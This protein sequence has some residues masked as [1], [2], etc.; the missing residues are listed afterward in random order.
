MVRDCSTHTSTGCS[1]SGGYRTQCATDY[2]GEEV[3]SCDQL[4]SDVTVE[5]Y[6]RLLRYG[7]PKD[8]AHDLACD[9]VFVFGML[10]LEMLDKIP[11]DSVTGD[12]RITG[13]ILELLYCGTK[14]S[15]YTV[16]DMCDYLRADGYTMN[17]DDVYGAIKSA[18][19]SRVL[20]ICL[21]HLYTTRAPAQ[22]LD[23][24]YFDKIA[25]ECLNIQNTGIQL[26][27]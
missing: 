18:Q 2:A 15:R 16:E 1:L 7:L 17:E 19:V 23:R 21:L 20:F 10:F 3:E 8:R 9:A 14:V 6:G 22:E 4:G 26:K 11:C 24:A 25:K 5:M 12:A 13:E 27:F